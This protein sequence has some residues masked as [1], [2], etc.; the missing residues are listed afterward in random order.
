VAR[1]AQAVCGRERVRDVLWLKLLLVPS[2]MAAVT[3]AGRRWGPAVA[4]VLV[5]LPLT[6]APVVFL[7]ALEHGT[8]F[9]AQS[10]VGVLV[11]LVPLGSFYLAYGLLAQRARWP[12]CAAAGWC[13]YLV[14]AVALRAAAPSPLTAFLGAVAFLAVVVVLLPRGAPGR[15]A[16]RAPSWD[17]PFR[18][19]TA[20]AVVIALTAL[21]HTLGPRL[22]GLLAPFPVTG[23][24]LSIFT[25]RLDGDHAVIRLIRGMG[26][27]SFTFAA[28]FLVL[29][30]LL[31]RRGT[32]AAFGVAIAVAVVMHGV[33]LTGPSTRPARSRSDR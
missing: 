5:G 25:Q 19:V 20:T 24:V 23:A 14:A 16:A 7:L 11:G 28:F 22:S 8:A 15:P 9:A 32:A 1:G 4:G 31:D 26:L 10:A 27:A 13:A 12:A 30:E 6:S 2:L 21:A 17:I 29:A 3:L 33:L 18:M